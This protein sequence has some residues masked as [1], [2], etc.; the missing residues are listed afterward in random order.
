[1][2]D[3]VSFRDNSEQDT[4]NL[5]AICRSQD[6]TQISIDSSHEAL[7]QSYALLHEAG[8]LL[9]QGDGRR[10]TVLTLTNLSGFNLLNEPNEAC[11]VTDIRSAS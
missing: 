3:R 7:R 6:S 9:S 4:E 5:Q 11:F 2:T 8:R 10:R 1:M